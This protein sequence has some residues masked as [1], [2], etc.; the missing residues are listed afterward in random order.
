MARRVMMWM[1]QRV[2][3]VQSDTM[4]LVSHSHAMVAMVHWWLGLQEPYSR[5]REV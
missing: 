4:L 3:G 5:S 1:E 2:R